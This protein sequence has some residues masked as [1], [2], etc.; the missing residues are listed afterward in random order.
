M[1]MTPSVILSL[2]ATFSARPSTCAGINA[3]TEAAAAAPSTKKSRRVDL[4]G[5][6]MKHLREKNRRWV[7]SRGSKRG[8]RT[9]APS[10][11]E[12]HLNPAGA[13]TAELRTGRI[14][15]GRAEIE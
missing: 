4:A 8:C 15:F 12:L 2:G 6:L 9:L 14:E 7:W 13:A 3:A 10:I 11:Y 5:V 1:P